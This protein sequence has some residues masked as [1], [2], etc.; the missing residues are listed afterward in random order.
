MN[1]RLVT[2]QGKTRKV[3]AV[4]PPQAILGRAKGNTLRIPSS[5]VSRQHCRLLLQDGVV[6]V[7]DL[8][9]VNGTFLNGKRLKQAEVVRPGDRLELGPVS[10]LVEYEL[11]QAART[12]LREREEQEEAPLDMLQ[13]LADGDLVDVDEGEPLES[14]QFDSLE[15]FD[16]LEPIADLP[17]IEPIEPIQPAKTPP[18]RPKPARPT[19]PPPPELEPVDDLLPAADFDLGSWQVPDGGDLRDILAQIEEEPTPPPSTKKKKK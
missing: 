8:D 3:F 1:V 15:G 19:P 11:T 17:L 5:E 13:A 10:F 2:G 7:E 12:R 14:F 16:D 6:T 4:R 18:A 9:S